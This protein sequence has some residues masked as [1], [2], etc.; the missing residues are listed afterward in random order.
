MNVVQKPLSNGHFKNILL[1]TDGS[2]F[3]N[4][5]ETLTAQMV[6]R[7]GGHVT[8]MQAIL[9]DPLPL[10]SNLLQQQEE[11]AQ[12]A[13][14]DV[15]N[16]LGQQGVSCAQMIRKGE[17]PHQ[18][19]IHAAIEIDADVVIMGRRGRRGLARM[20]LGDTTARVVAQSPRMVLVVPKSG[21]SFWT[22][23]ILLP[24]DGSSFSDRACIEATLLAKEA[25]VPLRV[26]S[27]VEDK[28]HAPHF[29][30]A[31]IAVERAVAHANQAG[32]IAQGEVVEGDSPADAIAEDV[33]TSGAG[34]VVGGS[35][36]RTG[37]ERVF[38]GSV[39]ERLLGKV[40]C[41][42]LIVK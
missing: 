21:G 15:Q 5:A 7:F 24:T 41:P 42:V 18:E 3:A 27:V 25:S 35:H 19:I 38:I 30:R 11:K 37:L 22:T 1:A 23:S 26:I 4:G 32:V 28:S 33:H 8:A 6:N 12:E 2:A 36:G 13:L 31:R 10:G 20:M 34:L 17:H 14:H 16:R 9:L 40:F 29:E 39:M